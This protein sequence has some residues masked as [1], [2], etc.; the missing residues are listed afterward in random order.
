MDVEDILD[1][2][3]RMDVEDVEV[4]VKVDIEKVD[5]DIKKVDVV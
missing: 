1:G 4:K 5:V 3:D 2:E